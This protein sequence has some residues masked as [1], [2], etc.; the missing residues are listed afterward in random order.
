M[1]REDV[2]R[3]ARETGLIVDS[4]YLMPHDHVMHG[5]E[6]FAQAAYAAGAAAERKEMA[7]HCVKI[8]RM[9]VEKAVAR[10]IEMEREACEQACWD[11]ETND[12]EGRKACIDAIRARGQA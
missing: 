1:N 7:E 8:T 10:A 12:W 4:P 5:I 2:I 11:A 9:A 3:L 6:R